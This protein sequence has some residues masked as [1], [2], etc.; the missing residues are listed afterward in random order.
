MC[1]SGCGVIGVGASGRHE[2]VAVAGSAKR[3]G[4]GARGEADV[5]LLDVG[6]PGKTGA[7]LVGR[8]P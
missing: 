6:L 4:N 5:A 1:I 8:S 2:V 3:P 7:E